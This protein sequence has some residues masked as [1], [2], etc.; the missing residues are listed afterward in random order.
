MGLCLPSKD[1]LLVLNI[2]ATLNIMSIQ[3]QDVYANATTLLTALGSGSGL[4]LSDPNNPVVS[5]LTV[6][7]SMTASST[8]TNYLN[9]S[10]FFR[11]GSLAC[12]SM[13]TTTF[14][15][16]GTLQTASTNTVS[17]QTSTLTGVSSI[18]GVNWAAIT[19][20]LAG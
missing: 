7:G 20:T 2:F 9:V 1:C 12:S 17:L 19:S 16:S 15:V 18:N 11:G 13:Y 5:T 4:G 3:S 10:G 6:N 14:G 8:F